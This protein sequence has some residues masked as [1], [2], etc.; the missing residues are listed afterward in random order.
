MQHFEFF[1]QI[2]LSFFYFKDKDALNQ[3]TDKN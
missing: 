2:Q 1:K 3:N